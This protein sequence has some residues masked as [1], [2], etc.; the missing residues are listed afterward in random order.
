[1]MLSTIN[2]IKQTS[3]TLFLSYVEASLL[4]PSR[5]WDECIFHY[6]MAVSPLC[7]TRDM[8]VGLWNFPHGIIRLN[9]CSPGAD[10]VLAGCGSLENK[11][12][13]AE[14]AEIGHWG[15]GP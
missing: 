6:E 1:M 15:A 14:I 10:P 11:I 5:S 2:K 8:M 9:T 3:I 4:N 7:Q 13:I 12:S